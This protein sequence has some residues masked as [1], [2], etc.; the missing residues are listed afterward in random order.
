MD[1]EDI[2]Y[3]QKRGAFVLP[4]TELQDACLRCYFQH[5][6]PQFPIVDPVHITSIVK[7]TKVDGEKLSLLLLHALIFVGSTWVP[8]KFVRKLGFLSR[9]AFRR[10]IHKKM[11]L[12]YDAD[13]ETDRVCLIQIFIL[14]TFWFE[15]PNENK[16]GWH[17]IGVALSLSR[18]IGLHQASTDPNMD[19]ARNKQRRR[20]WW[21]LATRDV[22]CSF[23]LSRSPRIGDLDHN[24]PMLGLEDFDFQQ[25]PEDLFPGVLPPSL[26]RQR[27]SAQLCVSFVRLFHLFGRICKAA[28]PE[29]GTGKTA[30]LYSSQQL[31]GTDRLGSERKP[32]SNMDELKSL[33]RDLDEWRQGIPDELWHTSNMPPNPTGLERAEL[34]HRGVLSMMYYA[35]LMILHRPRMLPAGSMLNTVEPMQEITPDPSRAMVRF[36]ARQITRIAMDFYEEDLVESLGATSITCLVL[37]SITHLFDMISDDLL[38]RSEAHQRLVQCK[39]VFHAF[40]D[41]QFGGPWALHV[42]EYISNRLNRHKLAHGEDP[43][44]LKQLRM[45]FTTGNKSIADVGGFTASSGAND[46]LD[47]HL[48]APPSLAFMPSSDQQQQ[49]STMG[50]DPVNDGSGT[51]KVLA[52]DFT[53]NI[54]VSWM[55]RQPFG[56]TTDINDMLPPLALDQPLPDNLAHFL[57]PD[58]AWLDFP[59][60]SD[61]MNGFSWADIGG[62]AL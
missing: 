39:A 8:V 61:T 3:L 62:P 47:H 16:D 55:P 32:A 50:R 15:G 4:E 38:V 11:R 41:Q 43:L 20:L 46:Q 54:P 45:Q 59:D 14:W 9:N 21:V 33:E 27:V 49:R 34:A 28:Y 31:E 7:G 40:S 2:Q 18:I 52:S 17:W 5:V 13:Y 25:P 23:A 10:T 42:I 53:P 48:R 6:Q 56:G 19:P 60:A 22:I 35:T 26:S 1:P 12:L 36:A 37:A 51:S 29:F 24:V 30:V 57:G 58:L 44:T